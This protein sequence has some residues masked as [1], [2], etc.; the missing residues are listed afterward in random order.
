MDRY[1]SHRPEEVATGQVDHNFAKSRPFG[2]ES[3]GISAFVKD[4]EGAIFH[5]C[6]SYGRGLDSLMATYH[7]ADLPAKGRDEAEPPYPMAWVRLHAS[8]GG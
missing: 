3:P 7:Y 8:Y 1:V 5:A 2:G 4:E 6:S